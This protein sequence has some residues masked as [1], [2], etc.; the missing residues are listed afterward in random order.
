MDDEEFEAREPARE[1]PSPADEEIDPKWLIEHAARRQKWID[2]GQTL[3]LRTS[4][5]DLGKLAEIYMQAWEKGIKTIHQFC[6]AAR[7]S[8]EAKTV[9]AAVMA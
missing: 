6:L 9:E 5:K 4:E 3:T 8:T 7:P 1:R 2:M